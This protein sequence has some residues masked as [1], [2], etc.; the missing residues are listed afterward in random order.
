MLDIVL[1][2]SENWS[3]NKNDIVMIE[4]FHH[5]AMR[6]IFK[7]LVS[8]VKEDKIKNATIKEWFRNIEPMVRMWR[9]IKLLFLGK[10]FILEP[11]KFL[12]HMLT[13]TTRG[14]R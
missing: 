7:V 11:S 10:I 12:L 3:G 5:K 4:A 14:E 13:A 9:R 6:R 8:R 1:W 2:G